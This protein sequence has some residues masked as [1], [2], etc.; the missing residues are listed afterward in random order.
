MANVPPI[1]NPG[2]SSTS[3][4]KPNVAL[5][6]FSVVAVAV[7]VPCMAIPA[8]VLFPVFQEAKVAAQKTLSVSN[9]KQQATGVALYTAD[10]DD[11]LPLA[12]NWRA[13]TASYVDDA[14]V[15]DFPPVREGWQYAF[16]GPVS[17]L[18]RSELADPRDTP[19]I[20]ESRAT[21]SPTV[22][23]VSDFPR[24]GP[25]RPAEFNMAFVDS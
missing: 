18:V 12:S 9:L 22:G 17:G 1:Q 2:P 7:C 6:V 25:W 3:R 20:F 10:N 21:G 4:K 16:Y 24:E 14:A 5:I 19:L 13:A 23:G 11:R 8:A 15:F